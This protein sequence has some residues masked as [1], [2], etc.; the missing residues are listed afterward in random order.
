MKLV[1]VKTRQPAAKLGLEPATSAYLIQLDHLKIR[2]FS[3]YRVQR[4]VERHYFVS[5]QNELALLKEAVC[6]TLSAPVA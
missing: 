6:V 3:R 5:R 1:H 4:W 2:S